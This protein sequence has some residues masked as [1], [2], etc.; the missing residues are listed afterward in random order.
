MRMNGSRKSVAFCANTAGCRRTSAECAG[1]P[2]SVDGK[3]SREA[4]AG[5][6]GTWNDSNPRKSVS[7]RQVSRAAV[8]ALLRFAHVTTL[9]RAVALFPAVVVRE[10]ARGAGGV[11]RI[12]D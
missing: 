2:S 8:R 5:L 12:G 1:W 7:S 3:A 4:T 9:N 11:L 10:D 6:A